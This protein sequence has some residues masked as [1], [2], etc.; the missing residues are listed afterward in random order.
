MNAY[1]C[2]QKRNNLPKLNLP[3]Y[4]RANM[5]MQTIQCGEIK[6]KPV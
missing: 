4:Q 5:K 1:T 6:L 2:I 3:I